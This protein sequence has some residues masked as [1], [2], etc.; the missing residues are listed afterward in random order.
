MVLSS[1]GLGG[2]VGAVLGKQKALVI[3]ETQLPLDSELRGLLISRTRS[4]GSNGSNESPTDRD[5]AEL[6]QNSCNSLGNNDQEPLWD[7]DAASFPDKNTQN[8]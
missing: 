6:D 8:E 5:S 7:P 1:F 2:Y 3:L 4:R